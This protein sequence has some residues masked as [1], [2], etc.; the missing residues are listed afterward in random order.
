M[1][2]SRPLPSTVKYKW[3]YYVLILKVRCG[4]LLSFIHNDYMWQQNFSKAECHLF[5]VRLRGLHMRTL[6][7]SWSGFSN[8]LT[9]HMVDI[10]R[11]RWQITPLPTIYPPLNSMSANAKDSMVES[12]LL[13][14][15]TIQFSTLGGSLAIAC[16][17]FWTSSV[18]LSWGKTSVTNPQ[19][20]AS[21]AVSLRPA[22]NISL[23]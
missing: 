2:N 11:N 14:N 23:D 17:L 19:S 22:S 4:K 20:L 16:T 10:I 7:F 5:L 8:L 13:W 1:H 18:N 3:S 21:T 12:P 9:W 6:E 15:A